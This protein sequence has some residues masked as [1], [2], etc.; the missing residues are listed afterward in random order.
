MAKLMWVEATNTAEAGRVVLWDRDDAHP[1][2]EV[3]IRAGEGPVRVC[4]TTDAI[5][6]KLAAGEIREVESP[7]KREKSAP[8]GSPRG[9]SA[10]VN[11]EHDEGPGDIDSAGLE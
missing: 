5:R 3:L 8:A 10:A 6:G 2:G 7:N 4:A 9:T 11:S 1:T